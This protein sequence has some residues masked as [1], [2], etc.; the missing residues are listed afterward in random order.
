LHYKNI[1]LTFWGHF[2]VQT[3]FYLL[4]P[5]TLFNGLLTRENI[6]DGFLR[7]IFSLTGSLRGQDNG[8]FAR[9]DPDSP[10]IVS[11]MFDINTVFAVIDVFLRYLAAVPTGIAV[12][13]KPAELDGILP[14]EAVIAHPVGEKDRNQTFSFHAEVIITLNADCPAKV[15]IGMRAERRARIDTGVINPSVS[16]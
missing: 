4:N 13:N 8:R 7:R 3:L 10:L 2:T 15:I 14:E 16:A 11:P 9:R 12:T 5:V 1:C 6:L